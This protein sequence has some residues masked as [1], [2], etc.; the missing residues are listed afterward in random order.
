MNNTCNCVVSNSCQGYLRV[1]PADLILPGLVVGCS[2]IEGLRLS[3]LECFYSSD[4]ISTIITYLEY[5]IQMDGSPPNNFV[6]PII[7]PIAIRPLD[8]STN[9]QFLPNSSIGTL[10]SEL[11]IEELISTSS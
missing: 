10:I 1:G 3:T 8:N 6:P 2:P 4:C 11:F 5:Y 9:S 7:P